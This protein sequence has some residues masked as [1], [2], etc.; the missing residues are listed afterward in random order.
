MRSNALNTWR[1]PRSQILGLSL[2]FGD[3]LL[4]HVPRLSPPN[5]FAPVSTPAKSTFALSHF[6]VCLRGNS[7]EPLSRLNLLDS[8]SEVN[9]A[10]DS[11]QDR[12]NTDA[13]S[14][15]RHS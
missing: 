1:K 11:T 7:Q 5:I 12:P 8:G 13:L 4:T 6:S 15:C 9:E 14:A 2:R 10:Q 3:A